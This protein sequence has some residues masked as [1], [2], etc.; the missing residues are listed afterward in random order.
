[1]VLGK[2]IYSRTISSPCR[3]L[4]TTM[5]DSRTFLQLTKCSGSMTAR[6]EFIFFKSY[7]S[8]WPIILKTKVFLDCT[9]DHTR[10]IEKL[11][12]SLHTISRYTVWILLN[13]PNCNLEIRKK[14]LRLRISFQVLWSAK[15]HKHRCI[16]RTIQVPCQS[17]RM[18]SHLADSSKS[19]LTTS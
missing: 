15:S 7:R 5:R 13:K 8:I 10:L 2:P 12:R 9:K 4:L 17:T 11:R 1:M 6:Q 14:C 18:S 3:I 16:R 19:I